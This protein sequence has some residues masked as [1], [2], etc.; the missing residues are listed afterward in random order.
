MVSTWSDVRRSS[1]VMASA[2][3][4]P[5]TRLAG[6][7][8]MLATEA[9]D[10]G[11]QRLRLEYRHI[12]EQLAS[13]G[14]AAS[15]RPLA[16][17]ELGELGELLDDH[18]DARILHLSG[19]LGNEGPRLLESAIKG[20][21]SPGAAEFMSAF[22]RKHQLAC[23]F[24]NTPHDPAQAERIASRVEWV[25]SMASSAD[26]DHA[27]AFAG[28]FYAALADGAR[29]DSAFRIALTKSPLLEL[30]PTHEPLL[31]RNGELSPQFGGGADAPTSADSQRRPIAKAETGNF[32]K[33]YPISQTETELLVEL[34]EH[35]TGIALSVNPET[36]IQR[37]L[38]PR[39]DALGLNR[40]LEYCDYLASGT[41]V[42]NEELVEMIESITTHET[43][44]FRE[45]YQLDAL[46]EVIL[47]ELLARPSLNRPVQI[48]SAGCSTGEE[49]YTLAIL[50]LEHTSLGHSHVRI[51]GSDISPMVIELARAGAYGANS[52]RTIPQG[53]R[54]KYFTEADKRW[55]IRPYVRD[56]CRFEV[57]NLLDTDRFASLGTQDVISCRNVLMYLSARARMAA[58]E[59]FF[60]CL[61]PGG[62]LLLGH[63]ESLL[64][65]QT[66]FELAHLNKDL[67][68]RK[69]R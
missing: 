53:L 33:L 27:I 42:A 3:A 43:Y 55:T 47:P 8:L 56:M 40:F 31:Y 64:N 62:Y 23:V 29:V 28:D 46:S 11:G 66:R 19:R 67:A 61:S 6:V 50:L 25:V 36:F 60:E 12:R 38:S 2:S 69:P 37:R 21:R 41:K 44:F 16:H 57:L 13:R 58:V 51:V 35:H 24:L 10:R 39:L 65:L 4:S 45:Q 26:D 14:M 30:G 49:A 32:E 63:S 15:V 5:A 52:F 48:W 20:R 68:Y 18:D 17:V 54:R 7:I 22:A 9:S 34:I 59:A 1:T